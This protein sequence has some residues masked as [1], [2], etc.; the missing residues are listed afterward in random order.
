MARKLISISDLHISAQALDDF[1]TEIEDQLV[2]FLAELGS[3]SDSV[4]LVINGDFLDF[5]Q[6]PPAEGGELEAISSAEGQPLCFTERQSLRKLENIHTLT[7]VFL[8]ALQAC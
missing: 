8:Q 1:D 5:V 2:G 7:L 6:A 4:E 3:G